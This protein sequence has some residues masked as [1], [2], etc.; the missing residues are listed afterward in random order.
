MTGSAGQKRVPVDFFSKF[1]V[2]RLGIDEQQPIAAI[3][4]TVEEAIR[5][6]EAVIGKLRQVKAGMLHDLLTRGVDENGELRD[7]IRHP[8]QF[9]DSPLGWIPKDW[10]ALPLSKITLKIAD[11]DHTTPQYVSSGIPMVSPTHFFGE[12]GIA[13]ENCPYISMKDHLINRKK[14][15][16]EPGDIILHRIGA[17][18]GRVRIVKKWMPDFSILHSLAQIRPDSNVVDE[19]FVL[20]AFQCDVVQNQ[21]GIGT[22]SIGVP[23][24]G[25]DKI[26]ISLFPVPKHKLE[27]SLIAK[28]LDA[29]K[30]ALNRELIFKNKCL[31]IKQGLMQDLL[32]GHVRVPETMIRKYQPEAEVQ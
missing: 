30:N 17:G 3:L 7:P 25:L 4:D 21:L 22:Q 2:S 5:Q 6:T 10:E 32:T 1:L 18:L 16:L 12:D 20:W 19:S 24:L 14:T 15:D 13:F 9:K 23:D 27:Q 8:E 11:R 31:L 26:G 28:Y 29:W